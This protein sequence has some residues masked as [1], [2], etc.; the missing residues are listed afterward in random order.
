MN[1]I[2]NVIVFLF[3]LFTTK[4]IKINIVYIFIKEKNDFV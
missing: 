1:N 2:N 3:T 4:Y